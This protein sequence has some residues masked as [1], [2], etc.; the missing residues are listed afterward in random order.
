[1]HNVSDVRQVE[2]YTAEPIVPGPC[3]VEAEIGVAKLKSI[4]R[5]VFKISQPN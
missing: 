4:D 3:H 5:Q 2:I 1:V